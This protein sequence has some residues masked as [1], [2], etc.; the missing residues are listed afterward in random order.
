MVD[1]TS[2]SVTKAGVY[3]NIELD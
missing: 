2:N 1:E 3:S